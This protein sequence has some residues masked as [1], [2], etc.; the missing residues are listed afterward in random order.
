MREVFLTFAYM[1]PFSSE[2]ASPPRVCTLVL[3]ILL[4]LVFLHAATYKLTRGHSL[5]HKFL[6]YGAVWERKW[7]RADTDRGAGARAPTLLECGLGVR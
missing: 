3:F 5:S 4:F 7:T 2:R 1:K 6:L